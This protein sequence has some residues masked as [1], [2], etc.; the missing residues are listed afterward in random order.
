MNT[1]VMF[2]SKTDQWATPNDFFDKLNEEFHFTLDPCADEFNHKC[3]K[4]YTKEDDGLKQS[5]NNERVF[6]NP[7]YGREIGK[8]VEKS[9]RRKYDRRCLCSNADS[10]KN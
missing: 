3:E 10:C 5:W 9:I 2:S 4:Y 6:C 7:P 1:E 8:W